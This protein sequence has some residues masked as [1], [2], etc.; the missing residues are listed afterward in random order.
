MGTNYPALLF[1][2]DDVRDKTYIYRES[3]RAL[4]TH[5][6]KLQPFISQRDN[7]DT[8]K[9]DEPVEERPPAERL[10]WIGGA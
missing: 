7:N 10:L 1:D 5:H 2:H 6:L 8:K 4:A 3:A 9:Y